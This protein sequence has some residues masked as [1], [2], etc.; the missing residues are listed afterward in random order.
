MSS[1][2]NRK[3]WKS[4]RSEKPQGPSRSGRWLLTMVA[5]GLMALLLPIL[6]DLFFN[7]TMPTQVVLLRTNQARSGIPSLPHAAN[8]LQPLNQI[9]WSY[10]QCH[11]RSELLQSSQS[12]S[13]LGAL[14]VDESGALIV[15]VSAHGVT[16]IRGEGSAEVLCRD[17]DLAAQDQAV[18]PLSELLD[19][20]AKFETKTKLLVIDSGT[21]ISDPRLG[22]LANDFPTRAAELVRQ[23]DDTSLWVMLSNTTWQR[24]LIAGR[25]RSLFGTAFVDGLLGMADSEE[26]GG[27]G[28]HTVSLAELYKYTTARCDAISGGLQLP[29]LL[30]GAT[31]LQDVANLPNLPLLAINYDEAEADEESSNETPA[32]NDAPADQVAAAESSPDED[33]K[34]VAT[35]SEAVTSD[36]PETKPAEESKPDSDATVAS[37]SQES[38][39]LETLNDLQTAWRLRDELELRSVSEGWSPQEYAPNLWRQLLTYLT[40]FESRKAASPEGLDVN[41]AEQVAGLN[42]L[43]AVLQSRRP[44]GDTRGGLVVDELL[45]ATNEY[46]SSETCRDFESSNEDL[47]NAASAI[48][49]VRKIAFVMP[50]FVRWRANTALIGVADESVTSKIDPLL[51]KITGFE[52][53]Y[54]LLRGK[55]LPAYH[56]LATQHRDLARE[57]QQLDQALRQHIAETHEHVNSPALRARALLRSQALLHSPLP[58]AAERDELKRFIDNFDLTAQPTSDAVSRVDLSDVDGPNRRTVLAQQLQ[59]EQRLAQLADPQWQWLEWNDRFSTFGPQFRDHFVRVNEKL[60]Q[61]GAEPAQLSPWALASVDGRDALAVGWHTQLA[62]PLGI[63][64]PATTPQLEI[65]MDTDVLELGNEPQT[66]RVQVSANVASTDRGEL[67][68]SADPRI[69]VVARDGNRFRLGESL[70]FQISV[71]PGYGEAHQKIAPTV[72][73]AT[74]A[75][76]S[77]KKSDLATWLTGPD[78][79]ELIVTQAGRLQTSTVNEQNSVELGTFPNRVTDFQIAARNL[80]H[81]DKTVVVTLYQIPLELGKYIAP[82]RLLTR[83]GQALKLVEDATFSGSETEDL[84][85]IVSSKPITLRPNEAAEPLDFSPAPAPPPAEGTADAAAPPPESDQPAKL[86]ISQ[87]ILCEIKQQDSDNVWHYWVELRTIPPRDYVSSVVR[88]DQRKLHVRCDLKSGWEVPGLSEA[89]ASIAWDLK[90]LSSVV[91]DSMRNTISTDFIQNPSDPASLIQTLL[92]PIER[93]VAN[94]RLDVD[95]YPRALAYDVR[96]DENRA[97]REPKRD[98][99]RIQLVSIG[100]EGQPKKYVTASRYLPEEPDEKNPVVVLKRRQGVADNAAF[101]GAKPNDQLIVTF[102]V[103]APVTAFSRDAKDQIQLRI[104]APGFDPVRVHADRDFRYHVEAVGADGLLSIR[105]SVSDYVDKKI[106][107]PGLSGTFGFQVEMLLNR[108]EVRLNS[109]VELSF[110]D[111]PPR[112]LVFRAPSRVRTGK[113]LTVDL[114]VQDPSGLERVEYGVVEQPTDAPAKMTELRLPLAKTLPLPTKG[115]EVRKPYYLKLRL[116]D[117]AGNELL[118]DGKRGAP[119]PLRFSVYQPAPIGGGI[120]PDDEPVRPGT[121]WGVV[122]VGAFGPPRIK[123]ELTG[124]KRFPPVTTSI[125]GKFEFPMVPPGDYVLKA[126]GNP[127]NKG[128]HEGETPLSINKQEDFDDEYTVELA[129]KK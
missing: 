101:P 65:T 116:I 71:K 119:E 84:T 90:R 82:G 31:P 10:Y 111:D 52:R 22:M 113:P 108:P 3:S 92:D 104:D 75:G 46:L 29:V 19:E 6:W 123:V 50:Y 70:R 9:D 122:K 81:E 105:N 64:P 102:H 96:L 73:K 118:T 76:F 40:E 48:R 80:A 54:Q 8:D 95:G 128:D 68:V 4:A 86:E 56:E 39:N 106:T 5:I 109:Q 100:M 12:L 60:K 94:V 88:Y 78:R 72:F 89:P 61:P 27:D 17:Y 15:Y 58:R 38:E 18:F 98:I 129:P 45:R 49:E 77:E 23:R 25:S 112:L 35:A 11:D 124:G 120:T 32:E 20:L 79:V 47:H 91:L 33:A 37:A 85:P 121:V 14:N 36:S 99:S 26:H 69:S 62:P 59:M 51:K 97:Y 83:R 41:L 7:K 74:L 125:G 30:N 87:G 103:D 115:L 43:R 16:N 110:D 2:S 21:I 114:D 28:D 93:G 126:S 67:R 34:E 13:Q 107:L 24:P 42:K 66:I 57:Y 1:G 127:Q 55:R 117:R 63:A 44:A 53:E